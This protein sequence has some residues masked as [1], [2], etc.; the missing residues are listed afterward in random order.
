MRS[1]M[2]TL[3]LL[4]LP[5]LAASQALPGRIQGVVYEHTGQPLAYADILVLGTH[6]GALSDD[7]GRFQIADV[8]AGAQT[9]RI[10]WSPMVPVAYQKVQVDAGKTCKLTINLH[11]GEWLKTAPEGQRFVMRLERDCFDASYLTRDGEQADVRRDESTNGAGEFSQE[12]DSARPWKMVA[13]YALKS[14]VVSLAI[15]VLDSTGVVVRHLRS[16]PAEP[17]GSVEWR[18]EADGGRECNHGPYAIRFAAPGDTTE[19]RLCLRTIPW[20]IGL[21]DQA[22]APKQR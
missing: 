3:L 20:E 1:R 10:K 9:L 21:N 5:S 17:A 18:G 11:R 6:A 12:I 7:R 22:G 2:I 14:G 8:P 15:D 4:A 16:G 19:L 13:H